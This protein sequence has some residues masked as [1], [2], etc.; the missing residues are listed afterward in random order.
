MSAGRFREDL[1]HRLNVVPLKVPALADRREDIPELVRYF[2]PA[3]LGG[4]GPAAPAHR[5]RRH[6]GAAVA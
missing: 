6:G 4:V 1:F 2:V 3:D 5:R